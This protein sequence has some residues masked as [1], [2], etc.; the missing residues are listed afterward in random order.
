FI[1]SCSLRS[2]RDSFVKHHKPLATLGQRQSVRAWVM[3]AHAFVHAQPVAIVFVLAY[4]VIVGQPVGLVVG[5]GGGVLRVGL[6]H[7]GA[8]TR[9]RYASAQAKG[10]L[11][12][13]PFGVSYLYSVTALCGV[14]P[15]TGL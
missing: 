14:C 15:L 5:V 2:I 6:A 7:E 1:A 11:V 9:R 10:A 13:A 12:G 3:A 8:V 4:A